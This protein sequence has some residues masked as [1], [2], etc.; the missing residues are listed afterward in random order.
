MESVKKY[1]PN[2]ALYADNKGLYF[3][4]KIL[5]TIKNNLNKDFIIAFE[6]GYKQGKDISY[7]VNKYLEDVNIFIEKDLSGKDR[8][9]FVMNK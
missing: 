2:I 3:Y 7:L 6:I 8:Y 1:E 5:K 4:E 9:I